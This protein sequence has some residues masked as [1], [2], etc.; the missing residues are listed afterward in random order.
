MG[1]DSHKNNEPIGYLSHEV[2]HNKKM[3]IEREISDK[4]YSPAWQ[5]T[6]VVAACALILTIVVSGLVYL[7]VR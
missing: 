5:G 7:V 2:F 3:D 1:N 4:R 6:I